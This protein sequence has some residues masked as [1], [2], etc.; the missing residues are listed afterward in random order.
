MRDNLLISHD[1]YM[2]HY[3]WRYDPE[4]QQIDITD[5]NGIEIKGLPVCH[6]HMVPSDPYGIHVFMGLLPGA[7]GE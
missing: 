6:R 1:N 3:I 7:Q 2:G 5:F 4:T